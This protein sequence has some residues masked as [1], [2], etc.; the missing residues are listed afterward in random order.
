MRFIY[1]PGQT[2]CQTSVTT[3]TDGKDYADFTFEWIKQPDGTTDAGPNKLA[4]DYLAELNA[5]RP[6]GTEPFSIVTGEELGPLVKAAQDAAYLQPWA[7]TT[8]QQY[9]YFLE[10][11][12]P[13]RFTRA[14]GVTIFR[15]SEYTTDDITLHAATCNGRF[16]VGTFRTSGATMKE[17][18]EHVRAFA[19]R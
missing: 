18:I 2:N 3:G 7:E 6:P 1:Q 17:H 13:E 15:M 5:K 9:S 19:H 10:V 4:S 14:D 8:E 16:F 11:L 12:P